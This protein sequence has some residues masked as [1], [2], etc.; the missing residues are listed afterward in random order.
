MVFSTLNSRNF[1]YLEYE[2]YCLFL[3]KM[4]Q[5]VSWILDY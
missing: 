5:I 2:K 3:G 1:S 4:E